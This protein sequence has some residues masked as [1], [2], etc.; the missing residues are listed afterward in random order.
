MAPSDEAPVLIRRN[1][2][3][4]H[5]CLFWAIA[6][7]AEGPGSSHSKARELREVC[8]QDALKDPDPDLRALLLGYDHV[9]QYAAWIRNDFHWGGEAEIASLAKHYNVEVVV[10]S[11]EAMRTLCYGSENGDCSGRVYLLYT[12][13]HYDPLVAVPSPEV[14][15]SGERRIFGKGDTT[16]EAAALEVATTHNA[17]AAKRAAQRRAKRIRCLGCYTLCSDA[18]GFAMHCEQVEHDDEFA[19]DCEEVEVVIEGGEPLPEGTLDLSSDNVFSFYN[20]E[21]EV[22]APVA[23]LGVEMDGTRYPTLEHYMQCAPLIGRNVDEVVEKVREAPS[24]SWAVAIAND[25]P[26]QAPQPNWRERRQE[27]LLR[28]VAAKVEQHRDILADRLLATGD[29]TIVLIDTNPWLG[30]AAP[31]GI[32]TGQNHLGKALMTVRQSLREAVPHSNSDSL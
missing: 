8:A 15:P 7:L 19:Y 6:Y 3:N 5:S 13:Q 31:G 30:M 10:V 20:T 17:A 11:C 25:V 21:N 32:A 16:L 18:E 26:A 4:D 2:P 14:L 1:V 23:P 28:A 29:K 24:A 9:D 22:F 27:V 12:G